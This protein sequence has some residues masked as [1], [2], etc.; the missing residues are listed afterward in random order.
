MGNSSVAG[1]AMSCHVLTAITKHFRIDHPQDPADKFLVHS[2][3]ESDQRMNVYA[4]RALLDSAGRATVELPSYFDA[5]NTTPLVQLT[6]VGRGHVYVEDEVHG[7]RFVIGGDPG[8]TVHWQ[9]TGVRH[10]AYAQAHPL[11][12]EPEKAPAERGRFLTPEVHGAPAA[13]RIG[14]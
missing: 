5:L 2:C 9:V 4:G 11:E 10:D 1:G 7:R 3:V 6:G 14:A 8:Q 13:D 12:V